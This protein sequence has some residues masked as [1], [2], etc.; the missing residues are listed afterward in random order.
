MEPLKAAVARCQCRLSEPFPHAC[1]R[2]GL[3]LRRHTACS[4]QP[5]QTNGLC[6]R[7]GPTGYRY[8]SRHRPS[9]PIA[10]GRHEPDAPDGSSL[11]TIRIVPGTVKLCES[12]GRAGGFPYDDDPAW[13]KTI[14]GGAVTTTR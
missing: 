1:P 7:H 2:Y 8:Q 6:P 11:R 4:Q 14:P 13:I 3:T 9:A 10:S 5:T 12:P